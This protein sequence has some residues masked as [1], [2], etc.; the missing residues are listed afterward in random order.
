MPTA[1]TRIKYIPRAG[2]S[3]ICYLPALLGLITS[4][5]VCFVTL[6]TRRRRCENH[7][8]TTFSRSFV[9]EALFVLIALSEYPNLGLLMQSLS[10][11]IKPTPFANLCAERKRCERG[12]EP[13]EA[14]LTGVPR[15]LLRSVHEQVW[16]EVSTRIFVGGDFSQEQGEHYY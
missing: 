6:F 4:L 14:R 11:R 10:T 16:K 9:L 1:P 5:Y 8:G 3:R 13:S 2:L 12:L 15:V 7:V